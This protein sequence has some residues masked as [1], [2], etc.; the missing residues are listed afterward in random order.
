MSGKITQNC[1]H[2]F[3]ASPQNK[4]MWTPWSACNATCG[5]G[6]KNRTCHGSGCEMEGD[7]EEIECNTQPCADTER[8]GL[9]RWIK[10]LAAGASFIISVTCLTCL[11]CRCVKRRKGKKDKRQSDRNGRTEEPVYVLN[12]IGESNQAYG[13]TNSSNLD[14]PYLKKGDDNT[15]SNIYYDSFKN[16]NVKK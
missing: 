12:V 13:Q 9:P 2:T 3:Q 14:I 4:A 6:V 11:T 5:S 10:G 8:D 7:V 16:S 1:L 15:Y